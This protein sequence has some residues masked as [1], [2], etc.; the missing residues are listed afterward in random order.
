MDVK[1]AFLNGERK[2]EIYVSQ[3]EGFVVPDHPN[4]VYR[5]KKAFYGL[6]KAP[7]AWYDTLSRFLLANGFFKGVVD[8]TLFI[9]K[10]GKL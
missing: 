9:R 6:K 10:T 3:P 8:P 2:E 1:T 4:H 7:R 5:L